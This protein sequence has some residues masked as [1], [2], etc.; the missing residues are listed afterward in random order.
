MLG[1]PRQPGRPKC[2]LI[3]LFLAAFVAAAMPLPVCAGVDIVAVLS[4]DL[5]PYAEAYEGMAAAL[6]KRPVR[7]VLGATEPEV[8][9]ATAVVVAFGSKAVQHAY[10]TVRVH[11]MAPASASGEGHSSDVVRVH[12]LPPAQQLVEALQ[13]IQPNLRHL[14]LLWVLKTPG[15]LKRLQTAAASAGIAVVA[16]QLDDVEQ[17]PDRLRTLAE[18]GIDAV[19][20]PPDPLLINAR[21]F[22]LVKEF[23]WSNDVP[24]YAP[25][26]RFVQSNAVASVAPTFR[27]I[28]A[29]AAAVATRYLNGEAQE[30]CVYPDSQI[31]PQ[32][33]RRRR[34]GSRPRQRRQIRRGSPDR[35]GTMEPV[36]GFLAFILVATSTGVR[37][38]GGDTRE[39]FEFFFEAEALVI[40]AARQP[41]PRSARRRLCTCSTGA[42]CAPRVTSACG[43]LCDKYPGST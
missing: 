19:W 40:S 37:A 28:R 20:L 13:L 10:P 34:G 5:G 11:C 23:A 17:L 27:E 35:G 25:T 4:S 12:M 26:A 30:G 22:S 36:A 42:R 6:G 43:R 16:P 15:Y 38:R 2:Y 33:P 31:T 21:S 3:E 41:H 18:L 14:G 7:I 9:P 24:F 32:R 39:L 8:G 1:N 29:A